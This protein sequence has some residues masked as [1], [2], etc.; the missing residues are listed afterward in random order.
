MFKKLWLLFAI[1]ALMVDCFN[2]YVFLFGLASGSTS[3]IIFICMSFVK[4][5]FRKK[6][7]WT[8]HMKIGMCVGA[9]FIAVF[10]IFMK[11]GVFLIACG[12][13]TGKAKMIG[14][15]LWEVACQIN[16]S[17]ILTVISVIFVLLMTISFVVNLIKDLSNVS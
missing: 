4:W 8:G 16:V 15:C 6:G 14:P 17:A 11:I 7:V 3:L 12:R 5:E 2:P 1:A 10:N 13:I 9:V